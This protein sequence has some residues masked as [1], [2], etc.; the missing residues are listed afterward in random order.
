MIILHKKQGIPS[1]DA[2]QIAE[3]IH[4]TNPKYITQD[5]VRE[6]RKKIKKD[7][8]RKNETL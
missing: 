2:V 6:F 3:K 1:K 5:I 8:L 7:N 4:R